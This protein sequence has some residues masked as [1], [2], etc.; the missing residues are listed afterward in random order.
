VWLCNFSTLEKMTTTSKTTI[1]LSKDWNSSFSHWFLESFTLKLLILKALDSN[2]PKETPFLTINIK[3]LV[4]RYLLSGPFWL[5]QKIHLI[6]K[7]SKI[8][9]QL[10]CFQPMKMISSS[11]ITTFRLEQ[12]WLPIISMVWAKDFRLTFEKQ[13]ENGPFLTEPVIKKSILEQEF[14]PMDTTL[15]IYSK[16]LTMHLI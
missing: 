9:I 8:N 7:L 12:E 15:S 11:V 16:V 4:I 3:N 5:I 10:W 13:Q 6:S 14:R 1:P 2:C